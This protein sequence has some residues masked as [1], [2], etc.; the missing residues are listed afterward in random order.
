MPR[1]V[2]TPGSWDLGQK[3]TGC[4]KKRSPTPWR[5]VALCRRC[6]RRGGQESGRV[7][8]VRGCGGSRDR[9]AEKSQRS[10]V[11]PQRE[12]ETEDVGGP[13]NATVSGEE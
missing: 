8:G 11:S 13:G 12:G 7:R 9:A 10:E 5:G 1:R 6:L 4:P 3:N 2:H